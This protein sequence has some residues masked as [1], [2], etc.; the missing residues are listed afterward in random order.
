MESPNTVTNTGRRKVLT[1]GNNNYSTATRSASPASSVTARVNLNL[2]LHSPSSITNHASDA[3][4]GKRSNNI[5][6]ARPGFARVINYDTIR[7]PLTS[8]RVKTPAAHPSRPP[9]ASSAR[10]STISTTTSSPNRLPPATTPILQARVRTITPTT[11]PI[12]A[13]INPA[14]LLSPSKGHHSTYSPIT[15]PRPPPATA[16]ATAAQISAKSAE[17]PVSRVE[18]TPRTASPFSPISSSHSDSSSSTSTKI[19]EEEDKRVIQQAQETKERQLKE[20]SDEKDRIRRKV[21]DL[22]ITN[23]SLE[24]LKVRNRAEIRD[25]RRR[26]RESTAGIIPPFNMLP[27]EGTMSSYSGDEEDDGQG[28][29]GKEDEDQDEQDLT[30]EDILREDNQFAHLAANL[31]SLITKGTAAAQHTEMAP[32]RNEVGR[33][34]H[35][36][37]LDG[38]ESGRGSREQSYDASQI[39]YREGSGMIELMDPFAREESPARPPLD[40]LA[41]GL[42]STASSFNKVARA[43]RTEPTLSNSSKKMTVMEMLDAYPSPPMD[44]GSFR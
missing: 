2:G 37:E 8:P 31:A 42:E 3:L 44:S 16:T 14:P 41:L 28:E 34:L 20:E 35:S 29:V 12:P 15:S 11:R 24:L 33:V 36:S 32:S 40:D 30:W 7:S 25:L 21:L 43:E 10:Y 18:I 17:R 39:W 5:V 38:F 1:S 19:H 4:A 9:I 26:L 22:E 27:G 23:A 13:P 6:D